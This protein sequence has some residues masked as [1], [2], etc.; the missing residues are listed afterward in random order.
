MEDLEKNMNNNSV[1][2][3]YKND[4][5]GENKNATRPQLKLD[6]EPGRSSSWILRDGHRQ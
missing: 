3:F 5:N 4:P 2:C 1:L 6:L